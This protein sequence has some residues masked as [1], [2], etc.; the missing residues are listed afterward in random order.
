[1][2][3]QELT[4]KI[5]LLSHLPQADRDKLLGWVG[6][7]P[8]MS[9]KVTPNEFKVGDVLMHPIFVH[10]YILLAKHKDHWVCGMLTSEKNCAEILEPCQSRFFD[11][12]FFTKILFT[13]KEPLGSFMSPY[14]NKTHMTKIY[15]TLMQ[16]FG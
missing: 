1:M 4:D 16:I 3:K 13:I 10:P 5:K 7:L 15:K 11:G 2:N 9:S 12:N 8:N 6:A 14:E